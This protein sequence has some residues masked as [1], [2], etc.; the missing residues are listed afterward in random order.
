VA[1]LADGPSAP[2]DP[3]A[4]AADRAANDA[5]ARELSGPPTPVPVVLDLD[6][7]GVPV[8]LYDPRNGHGA[9][10]IVYLH[11]G[12]W[13]YGSL[14]TVD[15]ACRRLAHRSG[16]AVLSVGYR[17]AP[18]HPSPAAVDDV[19][20]AV[21]WL[22]ANAEEHG[23]SAARLAV[24]GDSAGGNLAAVVARRA[25]DAGQP[26][27]FQALIYP[28]IDGTPA[29]PSLADP[30]AG[31]E[32]GLSGAEMAYFWDAYAPAGV[33]REH[34]D[35]TPLRAADLAGLPPALV[36]T[37]EYDI[38]RDEGEAYADALAAAGVPV[39]ATRYQGLIHGFFRR[40]A[41][42]DAAPVAVDQVA[43]AAREALDPP[44]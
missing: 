10:V 2:P 28:V 14:E 40:L 8:R 22:R 29:S 1:A 32:H 26:F 18:E 3:S 21:A 4:L 16:C 30:G 13:V 11:G 6:A 42:F 43:A 17:L 5:E 9:P 7:G 37:A 12:G 31:A 20:A 25:R 27:A 36:I 39:V 38:L 35:L 44:R 19:E 23:V 33:D 34:P 41:K 24:A 15:G